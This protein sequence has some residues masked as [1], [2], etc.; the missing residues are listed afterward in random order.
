M[1]EP[2][3]YLFCKRISLQT[4]AFDKSR[5]YY[6]VTI[7][8]FHPLYDPPHVIDRLNEIAVHGK[9]I[10]GALIY[11]AKTRLYRPAD[12]AWGFAPDKLYLRLGFALIIDYSGGIIGGNIVNDYELEYLVAVIFDKPVYNLT[13]DFFFVMRD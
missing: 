8:F 1:E 3:H 2:V 4:S 12:P 6:A 7:A 9:N 11:A 10:R 5:T 13:D